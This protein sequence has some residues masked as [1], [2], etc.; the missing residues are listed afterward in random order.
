MYRFLKAAFFLVLF[1]VSCSSLTRAEV[2]PAPKAEECFSPEVVMK[3]IKSEQ[4][5]VV[6]G[7]VEKEA[8]AKILVSLFLIGSPTYPYD[9]LI[10]ADFPNKLTDI[11]FFEKGCATYYVRIPTAALGRSV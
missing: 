6:I 7:F 9:Q 2:N 4:P 11:F 10:R 8:A 3:M 1:I 5:G